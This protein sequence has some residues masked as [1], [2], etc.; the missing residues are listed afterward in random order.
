M[1]DLESVDKSRNIV[2][3]WTTY[4]FVK[5]QAYLKLPDQLYSLLL[6]QVLRAEVYHVYHFPQLLRMALCLSCSL[7]EIF[8]DPIP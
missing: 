5:L 7:R 1:Q 3:G 6:Q 8:L 2:M 4:R